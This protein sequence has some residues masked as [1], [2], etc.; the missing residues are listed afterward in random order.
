MNAPN[1]SLA[2]PTRTKV[3]VAVVLAIAIGG[4]VLAGLSADT[5][6]SDDVALTGNQIGQ[7]A[8]GLQPPSDPDGVILVRPR[9]GAEALAQERILIQ[10]SPGWTGELTLLPSS[11]AAVPLP[12]SQIET[13]ALNEVIFVP[14]P[15]KV[16]ERLPSGTSCVRAIVWDQVQGREAS[17]RLES[18]CFDV[19]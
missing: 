18:W 7:G 8:D 1:P 14:G 16:I 6:G 13:N 10:L 11:G 17:E 2:Y 19:T 15:G 3:V 5:D 12:P 9:D 4:F